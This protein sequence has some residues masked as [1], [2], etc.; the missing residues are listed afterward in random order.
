MFESSRRQLLIGAG[1]A[2]LV[3]R[4]GSSATLAGS[5]LPSRST[6]LPLKDV[7]L[8]PSFYATSLE[9]NR[10]YLLQ[11][12]ADRLLHNFRKY[13]GLEPKAP[14]YGGWESDTIAGHTLGHLLTAL[15]LMHAQ[16]G[17][18]EC[19]RHA[20]YIV[21]ELALVQAKRGTGYVGAM[22]RKRKDGTIAD[23]EEIFPEIMRGD[24]R[25]SGFDLNGAWSPLYTVHK[26]LAGLLD[27]HATWGNDQAL[28]VALGLGRYFARV[29]S[30]LDDARMQ[31]VL[32]CEYGGIN[33]AFAELYARTGD[34]RW[35][36]IAERL[37]DRKILDPLESGIDDLADTHANTQIPKIIGLARIHEL[38]A[39][40]EK[41]RAARFFWSRVAHHQSFVI[42]GNGDREYFF[43]PDAI[44]THITEQTCE[45]C[46]TYNM[47]KLTQ[48]LFAWRPD[49]ILM[50]YYERAHLNHV[51]AAHNPRS[52]GFTYM[53]PMLT[54]AARQWSDPHH[55]PFWC[56]V[57]S[58][59]ESHSKHGAAIFSRGGGG[60]LVN[61]YIP[62]TAKWHE[63][64]ALIDLDTRYPL[65]GEV[66]LTVQQLRRP[67][68][69]AIALRIPAWAAGGATITVNRK[70]VRFS[71]ERGYAVITRRWKAKDVVDLRLPLE[72]RV[73]PSVDNEHVVS[74]MRGPLVLAGDLGSATAEWGSVD[75]ALIGTDLLQA[76][77]PEDAGR[78]IYR[79]NG[80]VQPADLRFVPFF[81]QY[82]RRSAV[83]F[84]RF[85]P[86]EWKEQQARFLT[87]QEHKRDIAA[88]SVDVMHLGEMQ[89]EHDH[90]LVSS[91]S[92]PVTYRSRKGRDA[93]SGGF[94]EFSMKTR[95]G[96]LTLQATYW[97]EERPRDFDIFVDDAKLA[98][99]HL[100]KIKPGEFFDV[101]YPISPALTDGKSSIKV[102]FVPHSGNTAG[103]VFGVRLFTTKPTNA[104]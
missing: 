51:M 32:S 86:G 12:N 4:A 60:L 11:L 14:I 87:E 101:D 55:D 15:S 71:V 70:P 100:G 27:V 5:Q 1:S 41:G 68:P 77:V 63:R 18:R 6:P 48:H 66:R 10:Q 73:E 17:C 35:L 64:G 28:Q 26:L 93:R 19:Q 69:F 91:I 24:I 22:Q 92:Y 57:G 30:A 29:F 38:A 43:E 90:Q 37:Y 2:G 54:G 78:A 44:S 80:V 34:K 85:T 81:S 103:P 21:T 58:G 7:R 83:Y 13:A 79:T 75:P 52:G 50:D 62:A 104:S 89:P 40:P 74:I 84:S 25:S 88:R 94:F 53:T 72:L 102:R 97:G 49:G 56:C 3:A 45:H 46:A 42:G 47:L 76:F 95:P 67:G 23:A 39:A 20:E 98:T 96:P 65:E 61:L 16:T 33:E 99:Q 9:S 31:E 82:E 36:R 8:K 59:M